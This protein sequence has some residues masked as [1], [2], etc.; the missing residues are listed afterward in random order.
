MALAAASV[1]SGAGGFASTFGLVRPARAP[2]AGGRENLPAA[3]QV[4]KGARQ[5]PRRAASG[6]LGD[7]TNVTVS[8]ANAG[9]PRPKKQQPVARANSLNKLLEVSSAL[10]PVSDEPEEREYLPSIVD[11]F[12]AEE[13]AGM[14]SADFLE[15]QSDINSRMRAILV[16]WIIE[17]HFGFRLRKET[18]FLAVNLLDRYL[19]VST[20]DR[21]RLQLVGVVA[22]LVASKFEE[23]RPPQVRRLAYMTAGAYT[24]EEI[25]NFECL[26]L[27]KLNFKILVPTAAQFLDIMVQECKVD[28]KTTDL[29]YYALELA[30]LETAPWRHHPSLLAAA[31][32]LIAAKS[33]PGVGPEKMAAIARKPVQSL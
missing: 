4:N 18:L 8:G 3:K 16:D 14:P 6:P 15:P 23:M 27:A 28:S 25:M 33:A 29:A 1:L 2:V 19:S 12:F 24:V 26:F 20:I 7:I 32:L 22:L 10:E 21:S 17:V 30:M 5:L 11:R 31:A 13:K 9:L